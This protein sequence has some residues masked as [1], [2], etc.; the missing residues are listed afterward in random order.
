MFVREL[1][2]TYEAR[3]DLP[4]SDVSQSLNVPSQA[5]AFLAPILEKEPVEVFVVVCLNTK[6]RVLAYRELARGA[7]A[8]VHVSP[9]E[10]F[11]TVLLANAP[12]FLVAHNHPSGDPTPSGDDGA[13]T[14]RL[15]AGAELLGLELLDHIVVAADRYYSFKEGGLL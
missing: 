7:V 5:A 9:A 1:R 3:P 11:K 12:G 15:V 4:A 14:R 2:V 6:H 13:L 10:V 8:G